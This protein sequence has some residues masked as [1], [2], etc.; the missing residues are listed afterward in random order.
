MDASHHRRV[1]LTSLITLV[2]IGLLV[3]CGSAWAQAWTG[4]GEV[5]GGK[6]TSSGPAALSDGSNLYLLVRG[7]DNGIYLTT[8][9][10]GKWGSWGSLAGATL[11]GPALVLNGKTMHAFVRGTDNRVYWNSGSSNSWS[12][13]SEVPGGGFTSSGPAAVSDGA[14]LYLLVR[15]TDNGIYLNTMTSGKWGSWIS[16]G[17]ATL[18][19]PALVLE[20]SIVRAFVRGT[21]NHIYWNSKNGNSWTGWSEVPGGGTTLDNPAAVYA[22]GKLTLF[23]QGSNNGIYLNTKTGANWSGWSPLGGETLSG[24]GVVRDGAIVRLTVRGTDNRIYLNSFDPTLPPPPLQTWYPDFDEDGHGNPNSQGIL[25]I[26]PPAGTTKYVNNNNDCND[27]NPQ[28]Y[29]GAT[30]LCDGLDN[31]CNNAMDENLQQNYFYKDSDGDGF[32][33]AAFFKVTCKAS[34]GYVADKTDCNDN[35]KSIVGLQTWFPDYDGDGHGNP[36]GKGVVGCMAPTGAT[37]YVANKDDCSDNMP[38]MYPGAAELCDKIDNNCNGQIDEG[39]ACIPCSYTFSAW[40]DCQASNTQTRTVLS[41]S[42]DGC[43]ASKTQLLAQ[44]CKAPPPLVVGG[45]PGGGTAPTLEQA[46][47]AQKPAIDGMMNDLVKATMDL[48]TARIAYQEEGLSTFEATLKSPWDGTIAKPPSGTKVLPS[49]AGYDAALQKQKDA[50]SKLI[51]SL[52]ALLKLNPTTTD[53]KAIEP[54]TR[55]ILTQVTMAY[56]NVLFTVF[57]EDS[58]KNTQLLGCSN[59]PIQDQHIYKLIDPTIFSNTIQCLD[60]DGVLGLDQGLG[61]AFSATMVALKFTHPNYFAAVQDR[62]FSNLIPY[63]VVLNDA[64]RFYGSRLNSFLNTYI[65][66]Q[67]TIPDTT[68]NTDTGVALAP[69]AIVLFNTTTQKSVSVNL[70]SVD[71]TQKIMD[72][73]LNPPPPPG[74]LAVW[75]DNY[76]CMIS[77]NFMKAISDPAFNKDM[78]CSFWDTARLGK[79]CL[80]PA[81]PKT[82]WLDGEKIK[83]VLE[84]LFVSTAYADTDP[85]CGDPGSENVPCIIATECEKKGMETNICG[86]CVP[87]GGSPEPKGTEPKSQC[88]ISCG[89]C[90]YT[91]EPGCMAQLLCGGSGAALTTCQGYVQGCFENCNKNNKLNCTCGNWKVDAGE[92]CDDGNMKSGDGCSSE[93]KLEKIACGNGQLNLSEECDDGNKIDTDA[94]TSACK[95]AKCGDGIKRTDIIDPKNPLFEECDDGDKNNNKFGCATT[96]KVTVCGNGKIDPSESCDGGDG[97]SP[98]C[99]WCTECDPSKLP[100]CVAAKATFSKALSGLWFA[101]DDIKVGG[102]FVCKKGM[103]ISCQ[104]PPFKKRCDDAVVACQQQNAC[105]VDPLLQDIKDKVCPALIN[106]AL[107]MD[108]LKDAATGKLDGNYLVNTYTQANENLDTFRNS[109]VVKLVEVFPSMVQWLEYY[110]GEKFSEEKKAQVFSDATWTLLHTELMTDPVKMQKASA[111]TVKSSSKSGYTIK[112]DPLIIAGYT[113]QVAAIVG[114]HEALHVVTGKLIGGWS[115]DGPASKAPGN[116]AVDASQMDSVWY[117]AKKDTLGFTAHWVMDILEISLGSDF[118]ATQGNKGD[119]KSELC[120][121]YQP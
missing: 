107:T 73:K 22:G 31:N 121:G 66:R 36:A 115:G 71:T 78:T 7:A 79:P 83:R 76:N 3:W 70:C 80:P 90:E 62:V 99:Q 96:C 119:T 19:G 60:L 37:K 94:C 48:V 86:K 10:G 105:G 32:G 39:N 69:P 27:S 55:E 46:W 61:G 63:V 47:N 53:T 64:T 40:G 67:K 57:D 120:K 102:K 44:F 98:D 13:W 100:E 45:N 28:M 41:T 29:P 30:E 5:P 14:N 4:W 26:T 81:P 8:K 118:M 93:C 17:G 92:K 111:I 12:A 11:S 52:T 59:D 50:A 97:C 23:I 89:Y 108:L 117:E 85:Y 54:K 87:K 35:N 110:S 1:H 56:M 75:S 9:T 82:S 18:S 116:A 2:F 103:P 104:Y 68:T 88:E 6:F 34:P 74:E 113:P 112:V 106:S 95:N 38:A 20:E 58:P 33:D 43:M 15:G 77:K 109:G 49:K 101:A 24:P 84:S 72:P 114:A 51:A 21:D 91:S 42:P 25:A 16:L 65:E